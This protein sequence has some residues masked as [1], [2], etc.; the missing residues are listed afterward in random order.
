MAG[1][2][3]SSAKCHNSQTKRVQ[4]FNSNWS[5]SVICQPGRS[6]AYK[7][8]WHDE[9]IRKL[10]C[11]P[12]STGMPFTEISSMP[13]FPE[14]E[15]MSAILQLK[16]KCYLPTWQVICIKDDQTWLASQW[17]SLPVLL[18]W[19]NVNA[20]LDL[21]RIF[22]CVWTLCREC[23]NMVQSVCTERLHKLYAS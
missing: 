5:Q 9:P 10:V 6:G 11:C 8:R 12:T 19:A 4:L 18:A 22:G 16:P 13:D 23:M 20:E 14:E 7:V 15:K 1:H 2:S 17:A 21:W 3:Q